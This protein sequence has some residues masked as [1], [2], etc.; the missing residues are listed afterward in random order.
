[1]CGLSEKLG[2]MKVNWCYER[3]GQ[4]SRAVCVDVVLTHGENGGELVD[5]W[6]SRI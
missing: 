1:M 3:V 2:S 6:N 4:S 5:E